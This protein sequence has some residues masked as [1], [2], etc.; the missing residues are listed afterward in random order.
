[1]LARYYRY[2]EILSEDLAKWSID[3]IVIAVL[4]TSNDGL[5]CLPDDGRWVGK[6][7]EQRVDTTF[8]KS[9]SGVHH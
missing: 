9:W 4:G 3:R 6:S 2:V 5:S 1:M 7:T 8:P